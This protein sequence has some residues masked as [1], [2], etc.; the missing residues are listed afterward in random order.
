M[1]IGDASASG[2]STRRADEDGFSRSRGRQEQ[3]QGEQ[4]REDNWRSGTS[5]TGTSKSAAGHFTNGKEEEKLKKKK[6]S[7]RRGRRR[8]SRPSGVFRPGLKSVRSA[9]RGEVHIG[10]S[11]EEREQF[12]MIV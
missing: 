4:G 1:E 6:L 11:K 12:V 2:T 9:W 8:S 5:K 10:T 7:S 3:V